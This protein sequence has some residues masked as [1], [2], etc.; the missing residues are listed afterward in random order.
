[1][2]KFK[3]IL[4]RIFV[5]P[6][7]VMIALSIFSGAALTAVFIKGK[8]HSAVAYV[9]Y[10]VSAYALTSVTVFF[11]KSLPER[12]RKA[13]Q[14][15]YDNPLGNRFF[16]DSNFKT[17]VSLHF[18]LGFNLLYSSFKMVAGIYYSS[19]LWIS[20]AVYYVLLSLIRFLILRYM[21]SDSDG[22][23]DIT[24]Y[25]RCRLC[26][27]LMLVLNFALT[28]VV[29]YLSVSDE[30]TSY[31]MFVTLISAVYTFYRVTISVIDIARYRSIDRPVIRVSKAIRFAAALVSML[32]LEATMLVS[33]GE[34]ADFRRL[35]TGLTGAG[36]CL[37]VAAMSIVIIAY[38][39]RGIKRMTE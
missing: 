30:V 8:P 4:K 17:I 19:L 39:N 12:F 18:S 20:V 34:S 9:I 23:T 28:A 33:F 11:S 13:R 15:V 25:R 3:A 6:G 32:S 35:M 10:P 16:T 2:E 14:M 26:G 31:P 29:I 21:H 22:K 24:E 37:A 7:W 36:I 27:I 38:S 5:I 1:M